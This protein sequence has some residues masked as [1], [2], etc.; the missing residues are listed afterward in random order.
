MTA[1]LAAEPTTDGDAQCWCCGS[2][3]PVSQMVRLGLHPEVVLCLPCA[4]Y[5]HRRARTVEDR[6]HAGL[7]VRTRHLLRR[8]RERVI[9]RG[10]HQNRFLGPVLRW[11][12]GRLP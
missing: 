7:G 1:H 3:R 5:V 8:A 11:L 4:H 2:S 6:G 9:Q 12:D 10:W